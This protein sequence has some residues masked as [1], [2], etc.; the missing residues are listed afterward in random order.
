M[1]P[2]RPPPASPCDQLALTGGGAKSALWRQ[3]I[4][5]ATGRPVCL[6]ASVE[7]TCLG[8]GMLA[9]AGAGW[10]DDAPAA[11]RAMRPRPETVVEP[12]AQAHATYLELLEL[13]RKLHPALEATF[14]GLVRINQEE[15]SS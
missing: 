11:A 1:P 10:F 4:A 12:R 2:S 9:A 5:D 15:A 3:I 6:E 14:A 7:A 8:A 13:Y